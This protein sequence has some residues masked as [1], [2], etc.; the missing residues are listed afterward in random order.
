MTKADIVEA[1]FEKAGFTKKEAAEFEKRKQ[2]LLGEGE[3]TRK[4]LVMQADGA[5]AQKLAT[6]EKINQ[7][8]ADALAKAQPGA[9]VPALQMGGAGKG[10]GSAMNFVDLLTAKAARI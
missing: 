3:A 10:G 8:Y 7:A 4:R 9:L 1:V 6:L 2:I 5:L